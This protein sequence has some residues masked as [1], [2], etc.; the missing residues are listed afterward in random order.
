M[1]FF[2][3]KVV[4]VMQTVVVIFCNLECIINVHQPHTRL[5]QHASLSKYTLLYKPINFVLIHYNNITKTIYYKFNDNITFLYGF[6]S[7]SYFYN[8]GYLTVNTSTCAA[9]AP[10]LKQ[11]KFFRD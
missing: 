3:F 11:D 2:F 4:K 7:F 8:H 1:F 6:L 10:H 9:G 5:Q